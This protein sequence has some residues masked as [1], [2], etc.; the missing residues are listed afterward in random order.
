[1]DIQ[2]VILRP[3]LTEDRYSYGN[4]RPC[5]YAVDILVIISRDENLK[6][7]ERLV[8]EDNC[9]YRWEFESITDTEGKVIDENAKI[10][11]SG[12][13]GKEAIMDFFERFDKKLKSISEMAKKL[14][15][16][17]ALLDDINK[18]IDKLGG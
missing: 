12:D 10:H 16:G 6:I 13:I 14:S 18:F 9:A 8:K 5:D 15:K 17:E 1:M 3:L 11:F 4:P 7:I 2:Q